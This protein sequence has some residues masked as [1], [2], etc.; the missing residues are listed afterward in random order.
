M[1]KT[2]ALALCS[3][4]SLATAQA[5]GPADRYPD[6]PIKLLMPLSAG[7]GG[8]TIGRMLADSMG[9][10]L[11]QSIFVENKPGASGIIGT[12]MVARAPKDGYTIIISGMTTHIIAPGLYKNLPYDAEKSFSPIGRIGTA[13]LVVVATNEF[14]AN[15]LK[16]LAQ[17]SQSLPQPLQFASWGTGST[18]HLCGEVLKQK[19]GAKLEHV[20]F[21]GSADVV[22]GL[23]GNH[24]Q[25]GILDMATGSP[26]VQAKRLKALGVCGSRSP[27]LPQTASY[28]EQGIDFERELGW[29]MFAP[30]GTPE[31]VVQ[32]LSASLKQALDDK[33]IDA[34]I[35]ELGVKVNYQNPATLKSAMHDD[36]QA[37]KAVAQEAKISLD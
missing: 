4:F 3:A 17:Y 7:S 8:D 18:G 34:K 22:T 31:P 29:F 32:K 12:S 15:N 6:K 37:W 21:K 26:H 30:A 20:P 27:S 9:K 2:L 36:I 28:K 16:G 5:Q 11:K 19:A 23:L 24:I 25:L 10:D 14:P 1:K 13:S 35:L 33:S